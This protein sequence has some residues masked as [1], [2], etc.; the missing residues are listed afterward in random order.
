MADIR[1]Q[2]TQRIYAC[3]FMYKDPSP[4]M[5]SRLHGMSEIF[6]FVCL[7]VSGVSF[8][9]RIFHSYRDD[10]ITVEGLPILTCTRHSW[11]LSTE[12]SLGYHNYCDMGYPFKWSSP[13][14]RD[15]HTCWQAFSSGDVTIY[16]K[17][18]LL[19]VLKSVDR[20]WDSNI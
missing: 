13:R 7:F 15:T 16:F 2:S 6:R 17:F 11:P 3:E 4:A 12:G 14:T 8:H 19:H 10:T 1:E 20:D 9:S 18:F 5:L